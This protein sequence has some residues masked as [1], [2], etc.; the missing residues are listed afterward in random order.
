MV[1]SVGSHPNVEWL[2]GNGLDLSDGVLCDNWMRVEGRDEVVAVGDIARFPN[3]L[4]GDQPRRVEHW[5]MPAD[6]AKRAA[7]TLTR[8]L[9]GA[10]RI[11]PRAFTPLPTFW[12]DQFDLRIRR[13]ALPASAPNRGD[14]GR[15]RPEDGGLNEVSPSATSATAAWSE[16]LPSA[17]RPTRAIHYRRELI[18]A[19]K[20]A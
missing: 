6:T 12:S 17:F 15:A 20:V 11:R 19:V 4:Y 7:S 18:D 13:S 1:E 10:G 3:P 14:G 8:G 2:E 5:S 9:G 16:S